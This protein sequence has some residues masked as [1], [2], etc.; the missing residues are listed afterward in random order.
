MVLV[1]ESN[2]FISVKILTSESGKHD[3]EKVDLLGGWYKFRLSRGGF[4]KLSRLS[5]LSLGEFFRHLITI[6]I[7]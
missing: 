3:F 1:L 4:S 7:I 6:R 2:Q 5:K